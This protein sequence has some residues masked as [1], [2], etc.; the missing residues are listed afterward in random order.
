[1]LLKM[2]LFWLVEPTTI[3]VCFI[4]AALVGSYLRATIGPIIIG[5]LWVIWASDKLAK[6][7]P[8]GDFLI[9]MYLAIMV[10]TFFAK[11]IMSTVR[12][13]LKNRQGG[14]Q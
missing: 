1:M 5:T 9:A 8:A 7:I 2:T 11:L 12:V 10:W 14:K 13:I 4:F 3:I 6:E